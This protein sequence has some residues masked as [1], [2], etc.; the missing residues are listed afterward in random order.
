MPS[1]FEGCPDGRPFFQPVTSYRD[2]QRSF[3]LPT[4]CLFLKLNMNK[5]G[6]LSTGSETMRLSSPNG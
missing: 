2:F 6:I 5:L 4:Y 3:V 1:Y